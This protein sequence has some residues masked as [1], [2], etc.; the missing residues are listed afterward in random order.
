MLFLVLQV[1]FDCSLLNTNDNRQYVLE[2]Y[3][4]L[5]FEVRLCKGVKSEFLPAA[6]SE[7]VV[8]VE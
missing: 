2:I 6:K 8:T 1:I 7:T 4:N 5:K 3:R